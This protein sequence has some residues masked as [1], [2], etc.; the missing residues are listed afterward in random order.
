MKITS[1][2]FANLGP[3]PTRYTCEGVGVSPPLSWRVVPRETRSLALVV[4][5]PDAPDPHAPTT[6]WVHWIL[7]NLPP[8]CRRIAEGASLSSIGGHV[9]EGLNDWHETGYRGPC[10]PVG[11]HR[12]F[13]KLFALDMV[14]PDLKLPSKA[15]LE[16]AMQGHILAEA[17]LIGLY[18]RKLQH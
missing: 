6:T 4:D 2:S 3:I 1:T 12:Y 17:E 8:Q 11:I 16:R 7:Y 10:P 9:L 13:H 14:L 15:A 5:D 18:Q